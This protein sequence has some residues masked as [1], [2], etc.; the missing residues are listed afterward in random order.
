LSFRLSVVV[1]LALTAG[2]AGHVTVTLRQQERALARL[3]HEEASL[4][5][6]TIKRSL[7][8]AMMRGDTG[9]EAVRE[10]IVDVGGRAGI[11]RV[12]IFNPRGLIQFSTDPAEIG[13]VVDKHAE[14]CVQCH[15][16]DTPGIPEAITETGRFFYTPQAA[17]RSPHRL[18]GVVNPIRLDEDESCARCHT[19]GTVLGVLDVVLSLERLDLELA[20]HRRNL[21]L[22]G[23]L[24]VASIVCV[25][26]LLIHFL[27][28]RPVGALVD[29]IRKVAHLKLDH[30]LP[31]DRRDELGD[32]AEAFNEMT[33]RLAAAQ[34]EIREFTENLERKVEERTA[35]L[36]AAQLRML[37]AEK[38]AAIGRLAAG[39]AHEINNPLAGLITY[40]EG[41]VRK[42]REGAVSEEDL[43]TV[44]QEALRCARIVRGLLDFAR[45]GEFVTRPT[46][47]NE[48]LDETLDELSARTDLGR[49]EIVRRYAADLPALSLDADRM[50]QA[51]ANPLLNAVA[52]MEGEGRLTLTTA[53]EAADG[54]VRIDVEDTGPGVPPDIQ[55]KVFDPFFTTRAP[56]EGVGLG[57]SV[58]HGIV[59]GHG[60]RTVL[61][62]TPGSGTRLSV[63]LP[64]DR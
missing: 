63:H 59:E 41:L 56:G 3:K 52:A 45:D 17:G 62:S 7:T 55:G 32:V 28:H 60:G 25:V 42:V 51:L 2:L 20:D 61:E 27:V 16:S 12:R 30:R 40:S 5:A 50:R 34:A 31:T 44:I 47:V 54:T 35:E 43:E 49:I 9:R 46:D 19:E 11:E 38:L 26:A 15:T 22:V 14:N 6:D 48:L 57:L 29:G 33:T 36:E 1:G 58:C 18:L 4:L 8:H 53:L 24:G 13:R 23:L 64:I 39:T 37:R 10:T 21:I